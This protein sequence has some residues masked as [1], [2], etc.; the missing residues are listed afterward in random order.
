MKKIVFLLVVVMI[1]A[2]FVSCRKCEVIGRR[3]VGTWT[4]SAD[5]GSTTLTFAKNGTMTISSGEYYANGRYYFETH[6]KNRFRDVH[7]YIK[8]DDNCID[9]YV[10][11]I[12]DDVL[13]L[14]AEGIPC[15][16]VF[17][18]GSYERVK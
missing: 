17:V 8:N 6:G 10:P 7:L 16:H 4:K 5:N 11:D 18:A 3:I 2:G 13:L 12:D 15:Y 14:E 9:S 1:S